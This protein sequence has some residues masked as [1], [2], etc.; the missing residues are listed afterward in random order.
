MVFVICLGFMEKHSNIFPDQI[1]FS[2]FC[3]LTLPLL[4]LGEEECVV[5]FLLIVFELKSFLF[6]RR[7]GDVTNQEKLLP[8]TYLLRLTLCSL[9]YQKC[10]QIS[11]LPQTLYSLCIRD[12]VAVIK[13]FICDLHNVLVS[14]NCRDISFR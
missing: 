6:E 2:S 7:E 4:I 3:K 12:I 13:Q 9:C 14:N 5:S 10:Y 1:F 8:E 11:W